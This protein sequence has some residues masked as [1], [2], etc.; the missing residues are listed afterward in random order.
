MGRHQKKK[1]NEVEQLASRE[2]VTGAPFPDARA[3][4]PAR[5]RRAA[6]PATPTPPMPAAATPWTE[7]AAAP[8]RRPVRCADR[9]A[10]TTRVVARAATMRPRR[11]PQLTTV[12][13]DVQG[14]SLSPQVRFPLAGVV[15][16]KQASH[17]NGIYAGCLLPHI[18]GRSQCARS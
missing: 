4:R 13:L 1:K 14:A 3:A 5:R 11:S 16:S 10:A 17:Q 9:R 7:T 6:P 15:Y 18:P 8:R 12:G 2:H